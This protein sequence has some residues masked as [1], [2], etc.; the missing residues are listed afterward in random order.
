M[1]T[2]LKV[3]KAPFRSPPSE[4][5]HLVSYRLD[6]LSAAHPTVSKHSFP[7]KFFS[8]FQKCANLP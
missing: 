1:P 3:C 4:Y 5:Q 8:E 6:A 2:R 7:D